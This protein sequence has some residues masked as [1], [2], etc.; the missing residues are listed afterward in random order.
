MDEY[1][2]ALR[3]RVV[4]PP[5]QLLA[6]IHSTLIYN[7]RTV[8]FT[9]HS[10][11]ISLMGLQEQEDF[12]EDPHNGIPI[13]RLTEAMADVGNN[14]ERAPLRYSEGREGWEESLIGCLKDVRL[15]IYSSVPS[16]LIAYAFSMPL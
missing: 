8:N 16:H 13:A 5:C 4:E 1:E 10:A 6:E 15:P 11:V 9:R 12:V 7:L 14:W 2:A 3:H